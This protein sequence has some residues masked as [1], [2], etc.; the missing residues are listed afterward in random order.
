MLPNYLFLII[1]IILR[2]PSVTRLSWKCE[3]LDGSQPYG[4]PRP[5]IW[6]ALPFFYFAKSASHV[7]Y[8][9]IVRWQCMMKCKEFGRTE[10]WSSRGNIWARKNCGNPRKTSIRITG[11]LFGI[12]IDHFPDT[13]LEHYRYTTLLDSLG[14]SSHR[15]CKTDVKSRVYNEVVE[16]FCHSTFDFSELSL[17]LR[18]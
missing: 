6:I 2:R 14:S 13:R 10:S 15:N 18:P 7:S 9:L 3:S 17:N 16:G 12:R 4:P 5:V 1:I 8:S 11:V